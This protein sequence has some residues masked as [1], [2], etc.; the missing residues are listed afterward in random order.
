MKHDQAHNTFLH[1]GKSGSGELEKILIDSGVTDTQCVEKAL[2]RNKETN[3]QLGEVLVSIGAINL[4]DLRALLSVQRDISSLED[5]IK[6]AAG[7]RIVLGELLLKAKGIS[8]VQLDAAFSEKFKSG[9]RLAEVLVRRGLLRENE[10]HAVLTFQ[11][12][13]SGHLPFLKRFRLGGILVSTG[14]IT[15]QQLRNVIA[16]QK[17]SKKKIGELLVEAGYLKHDQIN[18][19]LQLQHKL[20]TA[21]IVATISVHAFGLQGAV[22]AEGSSG[23]TSVTVNITARVLERTSMK[24]VNQIKEFVVTDAD[25]IR[26]YVSIPA[27]SRIHVKSNNPRGYF[28][29]FE[30]VNHP[31]NIFRSISVD[32]GGREVQLSVSGGLIHQPFNRAGIM[33]DLNYRFE[34]SKDVKPGTYSWPLLVSIQRT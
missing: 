34:L 23:A 31:D 1:S 11:Q 17:I 13:K 28:L 6:A 19:V 7:I 16:R 12:D 32:I 9:D 24:T 10:L 18:Q 22:A 25:I 14:Q 2:E 21:A 29:M 8:S 3:E 20:L 26:G 30:M 27:A 5:S 15:N 4:P 33:T